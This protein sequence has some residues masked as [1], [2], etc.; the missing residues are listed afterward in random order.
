MGIIIQVKVDKMSVWL[1]SE[2]YNFSFDLTF[3]H[4]LSLTFAQNLNGI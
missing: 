1:T 3:P 2:M 4:E